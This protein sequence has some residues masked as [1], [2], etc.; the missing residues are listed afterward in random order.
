MKYILF[1]DLYFSEGIQFAL[2]SVIV[3]LYFTELEISIATTTFVA[4]IASIPWLLKFI[5]GPIT[6][7]F[8]KYGRKPIIIIGGIIGGVCLFP[9]GFIDPLENL[10]FFTLLLFISHLSCI[11][12]DVSADAWAIQVSNI[13]ERGKISAAM[14]FGLFGGLAFATA[15]L[16]YIAQNYSF[17]ISF[18]IGGFLILATLV[19]PLIIKEIKK[20]KKRQKIAALL[21]FEFKK[22]QTILIAI[23]GFNTTINFGLLIFIIPEYMMNVLNLDVA[24]TGLITSLFPIGTVIGAIIGGIIS[25][26]YGRKKTLYLFLTPLMIFTGLLI[27]ADTWQILAV[28]YPIIGLLQGGSGFAALFSLFMDITNPR[29]GASQ[30]SLLTSIANIGDTIIPMISGTLLV[31]LGYTRFFLYA[32]WV[33]GPALILLY[34]IKEKNRDKNLS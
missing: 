1:G 15:L 31:I 28:I 6:D 3:I 4:G 2:S 13:H 22:R 7:F 10:I 5:F 33:I 27:Y 23:F 11:I 18:I 21:L 8:I 25:D 20:Y 12:L 30:Y 34:F 17:K 16:T 14:T 26:K 29:I 32:A 9:L 19:L 24:Q